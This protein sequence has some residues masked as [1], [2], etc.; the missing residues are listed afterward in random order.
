MPGSG[1]SSGDGQTPLP[2]MYGAIGLLAFCG[3]FEAPAASALL[4]ALVPA[5]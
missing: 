4:P 1:A 3:A 5:D 2:A